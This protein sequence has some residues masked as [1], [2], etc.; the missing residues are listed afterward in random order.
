MNYFYI[1]ILKCSDDSYYI[2]HTDAIEN[3]IAEHNSSEYPGYT[4][5]RLPVKLVFTQQF[6]TRDEAIV[7][8]QQIK[9]WSRQKKA[10]LIASNW[11]QVS[12]LA[13]KKF[14]K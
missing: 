13:K 2:G 4:S 14:K 6:T 5:T 10:A 3:R 1:Y 12:L 7:A 9:K 8:E 11:Q